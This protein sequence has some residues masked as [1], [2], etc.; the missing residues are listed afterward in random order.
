MIT[1]A[2]RAGAHGEGPLTVSADFLVADMS[3]RSRRSTTARR[4]RS[5]RRVT[6]SGL[7]TRSDLVAPPRRRVMLVD[8]AEQAQSAPGI[9]EAEIFE[10]LDHHHIGSIETRVP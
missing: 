1:L 4:W 8:H 10:I 2:A 6:R 3:S 7:I 9:A 5:T